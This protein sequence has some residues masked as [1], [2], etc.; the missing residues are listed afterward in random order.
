MAGRCGAAGA[1]W[2]SGRGAA[3]CGAARCGG[4]AKWG[5]GRGGGAAKC[6]AGCGAMAGRCGMAGGWNAGAAGRAM[7]G[8]AAG[9]AIAGGGGAGRAAGAAA[10]PGGPPLPC[11]CPC[12][13]ADAP[14]LAVSIETL[15][16]KAVT[17]T[18]RGRMMVA[19]S[20]KSPTI[21]NVQV[22]QW[23]GR[24]RHCDLPPQ[25]ASR[26]ILRQDRGELLQRPVDLV[27]GDCQR[28]GATGPYQPCRGQ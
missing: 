13:W 8:G 15:T 10:G 19:P 28:R 21:F 6:G 5:A 12:P 3:M 24:G 18:P 22:A 25:A 17:Q 23:F 2:N 4:A 26:R 27:A 20:S 14:T 9:R 7:A 11:P 16:K 1:R